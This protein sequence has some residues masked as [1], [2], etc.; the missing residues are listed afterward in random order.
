[1]TRRAC[2]PYGDAWPA[3]RTG[4]CLSGGGIR[5]ASFAL[6]I[7]VK[8]GVRTEWGAC[9]L[10]TEAGINV[11]VQHHEVRLLRDGYPQRRLG[12]GRLEV[13]IQAIL[14]RRCALVLVEKGVDPAPVAAEVDVLVALREWGDRHVIGRTEAVHPFDLQGAGAGPVHLRSHRDEHRGGVGDLGLG[15]SVCLVGAG[16]ILLGPRGA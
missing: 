15:A 12:G 5:S 13:L 8:Q 14:A 6:G 10:R 11:E 4:I 16:I 7:D 9:D 1:M 2:D 3:G